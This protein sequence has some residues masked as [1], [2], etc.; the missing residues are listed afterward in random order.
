MR[1]FESLSGLARLLKLGIPFLENTI[2]Q[3]GIEPEIVLDGVAYFGDVGLCELIGALKKAGWRSP[4]DADKAP[5]IRF[6]SAQVKF[7]NPAFQ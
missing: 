4:A 2:A 3:L 1:Q 7:E 6:P 5:M